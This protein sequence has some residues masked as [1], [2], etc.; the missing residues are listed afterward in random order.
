MPTVFVPD[1]HSEW[2]LSIK[3]YEGRDDSDGEGWPDG[4]WWRLSYWVPLQACQVDGQQALTGGIDL[5]ICD[6]PDL[7]GNPF[8]AVDSWLLPLTGYTREE[9]ISKFLSDG[10]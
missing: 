1:P 2:D 4:W 3:F 7:G 10:D 8:T 6:H 5:V 9:F